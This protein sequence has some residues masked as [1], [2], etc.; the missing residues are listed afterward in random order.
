MKIWV[1]SCGSVSGWMAKRNR[2]VVSGHDYRGLQ[3]L[4]WGAGGLRS[5]LE[6]RLWEG[7]FGG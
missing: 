7:L 6:G 1:T 3:G 4:N 5:E 2:Q